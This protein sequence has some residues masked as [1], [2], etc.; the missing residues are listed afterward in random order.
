VVD[1]IQVHSRPVIEQAYRQFLLGNLV[2]PG[3]AIFFA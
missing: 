2:M 3:H 1:E